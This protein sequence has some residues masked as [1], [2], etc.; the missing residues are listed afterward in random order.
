MARQN[1]IL[2]IAATIIAT[3]PL[4]MTF[5]GEEV[6]GGADG[7]AESAIT[8]IQPDYQPWFGAIWEPPSGE[9]ESLLFML[10][11]A[12]GAGLLGYYIGLRRGEA[13]ARRPV[14]SDAS[15]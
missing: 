3:I 12:L 4:F 9:I 8:A 11:A 15:H 7:E 14:D 13:R 2:L 5:E 10:Q 1:L 6:F